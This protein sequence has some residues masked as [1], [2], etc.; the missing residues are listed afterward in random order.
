MILSKAIEGFVLDVRV[1]LSPQTVKLY[2]LYLRVFTRW[3]GDLELSV[4]SPN[5]ARDFLIYLRSDYVP[6]RVKA[7]TRIGQPL[8]P[9]SVDNHWKVQ[10]R[11]WRWCEEN[12]LCENHAMFLPHPKYQL[13]EVV[14]YSE[15]DIKA[16]VYRAE[17][18]SGLRK[19][20]RPCGRRNRALLLVLL[21]TGLRVGEVARLTVGDV[22]L[23]PG[24][25]SVLPYGS[26]R[27]SR[28]RTVM[29]GAAARKALWLYLNERQVL[30]HESLFGLSDKSIRLVML[31]IGKA[32]GVTDVHPHRFRHTFAIE[33]LRNGGDVFTLQ[34]LLGHSS[35]EMVHHYLNLVKADLA[36]AHKRASPADRWKL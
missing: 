30:A 5:I 31:A 33:Y 12:N 20:R 9:S 28:A 34:R 35:L 24:E 25:I 26:A 6:P 7:S 36:G 10:R 8:S 17:Y 22:R 32:A 23:E 27:K 18:V 4:I 13:P 15:E 14:P 19:R 21:D 16:L 2:E 29:I 3:C 11:F 1:T